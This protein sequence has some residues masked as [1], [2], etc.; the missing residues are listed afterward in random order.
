MFASGL[1]SKSGLISHF[2]NQPRKDF[3]LRNSLSLFYTLELFVPYTSIHFS[4]LRNTH[5]SL[6]ST[7]FCFPATGPFI[8]AILFVHVFLL[9][10]SISNDLGIVKP[11]VGA[12]IFYTV[13]TDM[14]I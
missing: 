10:L 4:L 14:G 9:E 12:Y 8:P 6:S 1:L 7:G 3:Q 5:L 2:L 11:Y 13:V